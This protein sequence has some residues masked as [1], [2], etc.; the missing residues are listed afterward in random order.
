MR[1]IAAKFLVP[2]AL[3]GLLFA[4]FLHYRSYSTT[5][6]HV[7]E[8]MD[9]QAAIA[10]EF[11]L[12]V[13]A[14]VAEQVRPIVASMIGKDDFIPEAMS[15]SFVSRSV[16]EKVRAKFPD[17]I[18]KF[19]SDNPRNPVNLASPEE[20]TLIEYFNAHPAVNE[21]TTQMHV[22]GQE[23][24]AH[25]TAKRMEPN[26]LRCHGRPEDAPAALLKRYGAEAS[27]NRP[28]GQVVAMDTV[29]IPMNQLNAALTSENTRQSAISLVGLAVL[30][31]GIW[32]AFRFTISRRLALMATHFRKIANQADDAPIT[33][34]EI[35]GRDEIAQLGAGFNTLAQKLQTTYASL[36]ERV[37]ARTSELAEANEELNRQIA[38]RELVQQ[39]LQEAKTRAEAATRTKSEFLAN[40][41]HEV[42][43]PMT[44]ILG[45]TD[46]LLEQ[47]TPEIVSPERIEAA[48]TIKRNAEYLLS[49]LNDILDL[50]KI[51]AGKMTIERVACAPGQI[52][53]EVTSLM[54][55]RAE[56]KGLALH[57]EYAGPVPET[58]CT[59]PT[60]L[61]QILVNLLGNAIKFTERGEVRLIVRCCDAGPD[62]S[63][64]FDV[65]DTGLGMTAE[66]LSKLFRPFTQADTSTTRRFG[67]TGL[68]LTISKRLAEL[69]GGDIEVVETQP[70]VGTRVRAAVATGPLE[71]VKM[72]TDP[73]PTASV[74]AEAGDSVVQNDRLAL[75]G[76]KI[77]LAEDGPDN[78]RLFTRILN[79]A[80]ATVTIVDSGDQAVNAALAARDAGRPFDVILMDMQM[81][82]MDG[83]E[84]TRLLR[85]E[86][87]AGPIVAATAHAMT[88]DRQRCVDCG[89]DDYVSKPIDRAALIRTIRGFLAPCAASG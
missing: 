69:L 11:N 15:T 39:Q 30:L 38:H 62:P 89:C 77:L 8:S 64:Q 33:P 55:G 17:F 56:A 42:R 26:C 16:F 50:S 44:A 67:G 23:Y 57:V 12:A 32:L 24:R 7:L 21:M 68:G 22:N 34:V 18:V 70:G 37:A 74:T 81:P 60:R 46:I 53:E 41:S 48:R 51:E 85:R 47:N 75:D 14:Y 9:R 35:A 66:Q 27:F 65:A 31:G 63:L 80:G 29:A 79:R 1:S 43:T 10:M 13:R 36:E 71:G 73:Q 61:R 59:D 83:Y 87:Y 6:Q 3:L 86:G 4:G 28:L 84:A 58:L 76:C 52:V 20:L 49:V 19:S 25:F 72:I 5:R 88:S 54:R 78:Q 82:V 45:F 2:L 40:M